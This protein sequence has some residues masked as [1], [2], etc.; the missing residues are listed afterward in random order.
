MTK[1]ENIKWCDFFNITLVPAFPYTPKD[2]GKPFCTI[3][4][5]KIQVNRKQCK[6]IIATSPTKLTLFTH[7]GEVY[8]NVPINIISDSIW[9]KKFEN[10]SLILFSKKRFN[11]WLK[12]S[13]KE[14]IRDKKEFLE[15]VYR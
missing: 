15:I 1:W 8:S 14:Y 13:I 7:Q 2:I 6:D 12:S 4:S 10:S 5:V 3:F 9:V 11:I